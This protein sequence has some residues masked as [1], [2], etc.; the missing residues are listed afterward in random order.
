MPKAGATEGRPRDRAQQPVCVCVCVLLNLLGA[1][2][3]YN[4]L[5]T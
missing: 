4:Y 5:M 3:N 2:M 1:R